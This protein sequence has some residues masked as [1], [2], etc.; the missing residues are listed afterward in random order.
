VDIQSGATVMFLAT[1]VVSVIFLFQACGLT[2]DDEKGNNHAPSEF[3]ES[4]V[5]KWGHSE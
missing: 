2:D 3:S 1:L 5:P 4:T